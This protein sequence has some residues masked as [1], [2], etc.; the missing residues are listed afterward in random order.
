MSVSTCDAPWKLID[1]EGRGAVTGK[2]GHSN[3]L[4]V[5]MSSPSWPFLSNNIVHCSVG[6]NISERRTVPVALSPPIQVK[7]SP[8][9]QHKTHSEVHFDPPHGN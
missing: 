5:V 9:F 1:V 2:P 8:A 3:K 4:D 6:K 7:D